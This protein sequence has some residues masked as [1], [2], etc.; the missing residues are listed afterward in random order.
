VGGADGAAKGRIA[1]YRISEDQSGRN[2]GAEQGLATAV[3]AGR[4]TTAKPITTKR[5]VTNQIFSALR[6]GS[7]L[8]DQQNKSSGSYQQGKQNTDDERNNRMPTICAFVRSSAFLRR[9]DTQPEEKFVH[10]D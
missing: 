6:E 3:P 7:L 10:R 5:A 8:A 2:G 1:G 4:T 9:S